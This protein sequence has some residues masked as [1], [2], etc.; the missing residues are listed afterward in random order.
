MKSIYSALLLLAAQASAFS[1]L[2]P[3]V[4]TKHLHLKS[5]FTS[6]R[7]SHHYL[8]RKLFRRKGGEESEGAKDASDEGSADKIPF[9]ATTSTTTTKTKTATTTTSSINENRIGVDEE[10][11]NKSVDELA[12][13]NVDE[14]EPQK[15]QAKTPLEKAQDLRAQAERFRLEAEKMD[16]ILTME[17]IQKLEKELESKKVNDNDRKKAVVQQLESLKKKLNGE[18]E[19]TIKDGSEKAARNDTILRNQDKTS[20]NANQIPPDETKKLVEAFEQAPDFM[21][22]LVVKASGVDGTNLNI[23]D[24]I[25]KMYSGRNI[26]TNEVVSSDPSS[27]GSIKVEGEV[28]QFS[29]DQIADYVEAAEMLPQMLKDLYS[30][31]RKWNSTALALSMMEDEWKAGEIN[32]WPDITQEMI[33]E[34]LEDIQMIPEFLRGDNDTELALS[35]VKLDLKN[36]GKAEKMQ[37]PVTKDTGDAGS[38]KGRSFLFS[39]FEQKEKSNTENMFEA[40]FPQSTRREDEDVSES[41][42][43]LVMTDVIAKEKIW[44]ASSK[45][46]KVPGGYVI[47]GT[48]KYEKGN[49]LIDNLD[50]NLQMS[51]IAD[52]VSIFYVFDPTPVSEEQR[53]GADRPPVLLVL[54]R[55][56]VRDPAPVQLSIVSS[57]AFGT[58]WYNSIFPYL[59][60]SKYMKLAEEQIALAD[61]SM[62]SNLEFLNNASFPLFLMYIVIQLSHELAHQVVASANG[63]NITYPTLVPSIASGL[64]GAVTSLKDPPKDKQALFDFAIA[65]PLAGITVSIIMLC[66]GMEATVNMDAAS[67]ADLPALPLTLLRQSSLGGGI[68]DGIAPGLLDL[69]DAALN[70]KPIADVNIPL[71]PFAIAG[72]L[73]LLINAINLLPVGRTDGGRISLTLFGRSGT[74]FVGFITLVG[75]FLQG[76]FG[77]DLILFFFSF[78]IFF[79]SE[80][81]IPQRNEVDDMDYSRA[82]LAT[83]TGFLVLLTVIPM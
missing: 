55:N 51:R 46:E 8:F 11:E 17:K 81:E 43:N 9:F 33:N 74:Q 38:D 25:L 27:L 13:N 19:A 48:T 53:D 31:D 14:K 62:P 22:E 32:V 59:L 72:F 2:A 77:S 80:L 5:S 1:P 64:S 28:P 61:A 29:K 4:H 66:V 45:P 3:S 6:T 15:A 82:L 78:V 57:V 36:S 50:K 75:M 49:D 65:G 37:V 83:A 79:Q 34:K 56:V 41:E 30:D 68:I 63:M 58:I 70:S 7:T 23:T 21:K 76:V 47:R 54:G 73:G 10:N 26:A 44:S 39:G 42:I 24:L 69:P 40:L 35:L 52:K 20:H 60:N 16:I 18:T 67:Y 12:P 71:S